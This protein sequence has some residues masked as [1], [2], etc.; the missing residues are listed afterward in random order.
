MKNAIV[1]YLLDIGIKPHY[2]GFDYLI[3]AL[4][5]TT[6]SASRISVGEVYNRVAEEF[7][8][9]KDRVERCIRTIVTTYFDNMENPPKFKYTNAEFIFLCTEQIKL[10]NN[11]E[12]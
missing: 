1:A 8:V 6:T 11:N 5:L 7:G 3:Y 9:T 2:K 12:N 10:I 4:L